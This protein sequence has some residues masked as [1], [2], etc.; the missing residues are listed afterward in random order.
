MI[1]I[2]TPSVKKKKNIKHQELFNEYK[3][4]KINKL[5]YAEKVRLKFQTKP[6]Q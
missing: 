3:K 2:S 6:I 4:K 1:I 5:D